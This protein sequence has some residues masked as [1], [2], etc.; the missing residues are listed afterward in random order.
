MLKF[1]VIAL[2]STQV[3]GQ[4][5][6]KDAPKNSDGTT[7]VDLKTKF[8]PSDLK[9][10][11]GH[12]LNLLRSKCPKINSNDV[13]QF[14]KYIGKYIAKNNPVPSNTEEFRSVLN[15]ISTCSLAVK[16]QEAPGKASSSSEEDVTQLR[17]G[18]MVF[19]TKNTKPPTAA[20]KAPSTEKTTE[21]VTNSPTQPMLTEWVQSMFNTV[22]NFFRRLFG[23]G[24]TYRTR[25]S[26]PEETKTETSTLPPPEPLSVSNVVR[27]ILPGFLFGLGGENIVKIVEPKSEAEKRFDDFF[28]KVCM[29]Y[30][31]HCG[32][33]GSPIQP[34]QFKE[35]VKEL[36]NFFFNPILPAESKGV[37]T[38]VEHYLTPEFMKSVNE[39]F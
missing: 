34:Q 22:N 9:L 17:G 23:I 32:T 13:F 2:L 25:R 20:P 16:S 19:T 12:A 39:C 14:Q 28:N 35:A 4:Q 31:D 21:T 27:Y 24:H 6:V 11:S 30:C 5:E 33:T 37:R 3:L 15:S 7:T 29:L 26:A 38:A 36:R 10:F 8:T 1:F 18:S